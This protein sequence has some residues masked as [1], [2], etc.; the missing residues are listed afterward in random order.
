[1]TIKIVLVDDQ[2]IVRA[3]LRLLIQSQPDMQ[4]VGEAWAAVRFWRQISS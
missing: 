4:V 1:M 2:E 3:G